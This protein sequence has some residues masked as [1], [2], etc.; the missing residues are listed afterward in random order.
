MKSNT[1]DK[2]FWY[3]FGAL[4]IDIILIFVFLVENTSKGL[5]IPN[6]T[7]LYYPL[8]FIAVVCLFLMVFSK[9]KSSNQ[10]LSN[11]KALLYTAVVLP[12]IML[13]VHFIN[14]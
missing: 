14:K 11:L 9:I 1:L 6:K 13:A 4:F 10:S 7:G 8:T 3:A 2:L 12:L 5:F